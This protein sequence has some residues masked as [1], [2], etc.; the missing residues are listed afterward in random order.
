MILII[1]S[2]AEKD[3]ASLDK[4]TQKRIVLKINKFVE[5]PQ[6][7]DFKTLKGN[8]GLSRIRQGNYRI[9][10][11]LSKN[12]EVEILEIVRIKHRQ[13]AYNDL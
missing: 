8:C 3:L 10:C 9:I 13:G 11:R 5:N 7:V 6:S 1:K 2:K 12:S 4:E